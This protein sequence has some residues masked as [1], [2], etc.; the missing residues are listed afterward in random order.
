MRTGNQVND[1]ENDDNRRDDSGAPSQLKM[2]GIYG[3]MG[4]EFVSLV[5]GGSVIGFWVDEKFGTT[6]WGV[7]SLI[8]LGMLAALWHIYRVTKRF[9]K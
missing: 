1:S 8:L 4:F 6:P 5:V 9:L 3:A 2:L 7:V